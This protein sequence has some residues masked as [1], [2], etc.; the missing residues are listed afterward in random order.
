MRYSRGSCS[1]AVQQQEIV[2]TAAEH[3]HFLSEAE[4]R[5]DLHSIE[6]IVVHVHAQK[7]SAACSPAQVLDDDVLINKC[8]SSQLCKLQALC[9]PA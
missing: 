2:S 6:P 8:A 4:L 9:F 5:A 7:H 1:L 3:Q